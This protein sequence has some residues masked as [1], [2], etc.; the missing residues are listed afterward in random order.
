MAGG[1][2]GAAE[3]RG[4]KCGDVR[5]MLQKK[6]K[7]REIWRSTGDNYG[8]P[9]MPMVVKVDSVRIKLVHQ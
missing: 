7:L 5:R 3:K 6:E 1:D 8:D 9:T 2:K 4:V